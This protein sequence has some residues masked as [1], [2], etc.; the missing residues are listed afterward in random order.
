MHLRTKE[1]R[2]KRRTCAKAIY[3]K[4]SSV[5]HRMGLPFY[6]TEHQEAARLLEVSPAEI[7]GETDDYTGDNQP[8]IPLDEADD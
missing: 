7:E 2:L 1:G 8:T 3:E 5:K 6:A 4:E